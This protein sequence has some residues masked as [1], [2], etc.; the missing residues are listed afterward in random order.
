M[1][2]EYPNEE[3]SKDEFILKLKAEV[4]RLL[5]S[6]S[7]KRRLVTQ[8]QNDLKDCHKKIEDLQQVKED[9]KSIEVEVCK[10]YGVKKP[11]LKDSIKRTFT[12]FYSFS[13]A[14]DRVS[15]SHSGCSA[16]TR[17]WL[18]ATSTF[19]VQAILLPQPPE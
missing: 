10:A 2:H 8:L 4:Q 19:W 15:L 17:S 14:G 11:L 16:V 7:M 12:H 3:L 18:T 13:F 9:E 1:Q 5:G 6:N